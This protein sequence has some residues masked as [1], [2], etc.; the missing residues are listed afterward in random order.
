MGEIDIIILALNE[1]IESLKGELAEVK[2]EIG[3]LEEI[4]AD[5]INQS[6]DEK[7]TIATEALQKIDLL[8]RPHRFNQLPDDVKHKIY[9][10]ACDWKIKGGGE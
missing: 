3:R 4:I 6:L 8:I 5:G 9:E 7:L 10:L 1:K 2:S